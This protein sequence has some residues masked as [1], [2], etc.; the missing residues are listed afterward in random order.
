[1]L[2]LQRET[3]PLL[4]LNF[5]D[6]E[7]AAWK[8]KVTEFL[9]PGLLTANPKF[10]L[11]FQTLR[12]PENYLATMLIGLFE[13]VFFPLVNYQIKTGFVGCD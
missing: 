5:I 4:L 8:A 9:I 2:S 1:M 7:T 13:R 11:P 12:T 3:S 6:M 10:F